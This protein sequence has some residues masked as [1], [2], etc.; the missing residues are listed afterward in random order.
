MCE[1]SSSF[2]ISVDQRAPLSM[3]DGVKYGLT[4]WR[5]LGSQSRRTSPSF[6]LCCPDQLI[7]TF[8]S[9]LFLRSDSTRDCHGPSCP[10]R[11][12]RLAALEGG[13]AM[14]SGRGSSLGF[15]HLPVRRSFSVAAA[16]AGSHDPPGAVRRSILAAAI[17]VV[18]L[19]IWGDHA[20]L[21]LGRGLRDRG[22]RGCRPTRGRAP[23]RGLRPA[24]RR[25]RGSWSA[26]FNA[27]SSACRRSIR[28]PAGL[29]GVGRVGATRRGPRFQAAD[30]HDVVDEQQWCVDQAA[31]V[32]ARRPAADAP[33]SSTTWPGRELVRLDEMVNGVD[34]RVTTG[35]DDGPMNGIMG[36]HGCGA[37]VADVV[38]LDRASAATTCAGP[39]RRRNRQAATAR[40]GA[41]SR[42]CP[43]GATSS[44]H[45][46][47]ELGSRGEA[48]RRGSDKRYSVNF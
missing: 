27:L 48:H 18:V 19:V 23:S 22:G 13:A 32:P 5:T 15:V 41:D 24:G 34:V 9:A 10:G 47:D 43:A 17:L 42:A 40:P 7:N 35:D 21:G 45:F 3:S 30:D 11:P 14:P 33:A 36:A 26:S 6:W 37:K 20:R 1:S 25:S 4:C 31:G 46:L 2:A 44:V 38:V 39:P 8:I 29:G 16:A 12:A 28:C